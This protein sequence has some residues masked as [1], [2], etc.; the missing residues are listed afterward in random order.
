MKASV[1]GVGIFNL[2]TVSHVNQLCCSDQL[3]G[4]T[5]LTVMCCY[6]F[7]PNLRP[8]LGSLTKACKKKVR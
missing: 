2:A 3:L 4:N 5:T 6:M 1:D 7:R 8:S